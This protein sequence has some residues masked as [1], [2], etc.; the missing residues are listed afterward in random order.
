MTE[1]E[2]IN[3]YQDLSVNALRKQEIVN[4]FIEKIHW[5]ITKTANRYARTSI[6]E[7]EELYNVGVMWMLKALVKFNTSYNN[8]FITYAYSKVRWE[9]I[10]FVK[11]DNRVT[12]IEEIE[13]EPE[14]EETMIP[15]DFPKRYLRG[16]T[17]EEREVIK[18]Y[19][20]AEEPMT[21]KAIGEVLKCS[22]ETVRKF[23][24]SWLAK[25]EK[26]FS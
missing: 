2:L 15:I 26:I 5:Y 21:L 12:Y 24:I 1:K 11:R 16:L 13:D 7:K 10:A 18:M 6:Y 3:E 4:I 17:Y 25:L 20:L 8:K 9:I 22:H 23:K 19:I 14:V